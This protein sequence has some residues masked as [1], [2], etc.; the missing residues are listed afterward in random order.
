MGSYDAALV[1]CPFY[2]KDTGNVIVCE[3]FPFS[4]THR[5]VYKRRWERD[6]QMKSFCQT[7]DFKLC[8]TYQLIMKSKYNDEQE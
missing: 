4:I 7:W 3:G 6:K 1:L 5:Q 8:P 2:V